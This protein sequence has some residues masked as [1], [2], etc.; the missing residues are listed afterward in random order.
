MTVPLS[1][2][3]STLTCNGEVHGP[4][5]V[6]AYP[7]VVQHDRV[8]V[9]QPV[10]LGL[11][12]GDQEV[13]LAGVGHWVAQGLDA[14]VGRGQPR[15]DRREWVGR[16]PQAAA[17]VEGDRPARDVAGER[18]VVPGADYFRVDLGVHDLGG[19]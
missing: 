2:D 6:G 10:V 14:R 19:A 15:R 5:V 9:P 8:A 7:L 3:A 4:A 12:G 17:R 18:D 13:A 11:G 1:I 16:V